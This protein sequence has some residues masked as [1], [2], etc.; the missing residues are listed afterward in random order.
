MNTFGPVKAILL[1]THAKLF[2]LRLLNQTDN[3]EVK[4]SSPADSF[5]SK[6]TP[7]KVSYSPYSTYCEVQNYCSI[8]GQISSKFWETE[9]VYTLL[10]KLALYGTHD[11]FMKIRDFA[12]LCSYSSF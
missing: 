4:P 11:E 5:E 2:C 1:K 3:T 6:I 8:N 12:F 10:L 9:I 7:V